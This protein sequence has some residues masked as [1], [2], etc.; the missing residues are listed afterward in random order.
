MLTEKIIDFKFKGNRSY[1]HGTDIYDSMLLTAREYFGEYPTQMICSFHSLLRNQGI[2]RIYEGKMPLG[3]DQVY[4]FS[5]I[6]IK[7]Q[8]FQES[9][10]D[11][12]RPILSSYEYDEEEVT[13]SIEVVKETARMLVKSTYTYIEQIVALT[14]KLHITLYPDAPGKWLLSK[15]KIEKMIDPAIYPGHTIIIDAEKK[16]HY[17]LTQCAISLDDKPIGNIWFSLLPS[18]E[19]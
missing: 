13:E 8:P 16:F 1:V 17:R 6:F 5:N 4:A 2:C 14:K 9:I 19:K 11:S 7:T 18:K 15:I 3:D 10:I 12:D